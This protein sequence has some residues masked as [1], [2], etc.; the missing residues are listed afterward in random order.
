MIFSALKRFSDKQRKGEDIARAFARC[1]ATDDGQI[2]LAHLHDH[3]LFR[4]TDPNIP[5][6]QLRFLEGQRQLVLFICQT[7]SKSTQP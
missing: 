6:R 1:F 5:A 4:M 2:V 3:V 7:I